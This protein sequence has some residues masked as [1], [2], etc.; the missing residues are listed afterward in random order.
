MFHVLSYTS[1]GITN[2]SESTT[3][4][5]AMIESN[6]IAAERFLSDDIW[7]NCQSYLHIL[8][9]YIIHQAQKTMIWLEVG[10]QLSITVERGFP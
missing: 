5:R 3:A 2:P 6:Q 4:T 7:S 9:W 8:I 1:P 10:D